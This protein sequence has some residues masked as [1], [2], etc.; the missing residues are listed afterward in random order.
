MGHYTG[1]TLARLAERAGDP[2]WLR[3][4][5]EEAFARFEALEWPSGTEEEWRNTDIRPL[6]IE[7]FDPVPPA[8][9]PVGS[10]DAVPAAIRD[11]AMGG[12]GDRDGLAFQLDAD[13]VHTGVSAAS[14]ERGVIFAPFARV[15]AEHPEV[16]REALGR[17]GVPESDEKFHALAS[18][19]STGGTVLYVPR[20]VKVDKPIQSVRWLTRSGIAV[21]PRVLVIAEDGA[22]VTYIDHY[23]SGALDDGALCVASVEIYAHPG[24]H[25]SYLAVQDWAQ[26]VWHFNVQRALLERDATVRSLA[27]TL[28]GRLSRSRV[29][30]LLDG[31]GST[32][33][34]LGLYFGDHAQHIDNRS[35]QD[36]RAPNTSSDL[37]YKGALKG[38]SHAVYSGLVRIQK[39]AQKSDAQQAN[40]N[41]L[42]SRGASADPK[43]FL[44]IEAN[45]VRCTHGVSVGRPDREVLFYL[46]SRGL[47]ADEAERVFVT[48]FF[49]E[50]IDRVRVPEV[51]AT[52][53][54]EVERELALEDAG[55]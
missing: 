48:G 26:S 9:D 23:G 45:D 19:F 38:T 52:L 30:C 10:L 54:R 7:A 41:L 27:A 35:L 51:Q 43:P 53:E 20:G 6:D 5:R 18:A 32:S 55:V 13:V 49:Q 37:Y 36:H 42:L 21:F 46:Q 3:A 40:R 1:D 17:A 34:M 47:D 50:V 15:A 14:A 22:E 24:A 44:E 8:H 28:G 4:R 29:D 11:A 16:V 31:Q 39:G 33:E 2:D 25:V 12:T